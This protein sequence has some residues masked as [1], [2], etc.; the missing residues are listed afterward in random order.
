MGFDQAPFS[1]REQA[2][3]LKLQLFVLHPFRY[4]I[5]FALTRLND[6]K[7]RVCIIRFGDVGDVGGS[8]SDCWNEWWLTSVT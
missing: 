7:F 2:V 4:L 8:I 6:H 3:N 1:Q 5:Q